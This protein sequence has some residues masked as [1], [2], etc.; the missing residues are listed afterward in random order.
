M[1]NDKPASE[2]PAEVPPVDL[3]RLSP[4]L[5]AC[6][7]HSDELIP[8]LRAV[9]NTY[10]YIPEAALEPVARHL[11]VS[12]AKVL[13]VATFYG[14]FSLT[15]QGRHKVSV[16]RGTACHV[17][18]SRQILD[19]VCQEL[20]VEPGQTTED[21]NFTLQTVA[22]PGACPLA[23]VMVVDGKYYGRLDARRAKRVLDQYRQE[24]QE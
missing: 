6:P 5:T 4:A 7:R 14:Q 13:G 2:A 23:R 17:R 24:S 22:C 3:E 16:C 21:M 1:P 18:G 12:R 10:G 8:L 15:P 19:R 11:G 20:G 9:Q